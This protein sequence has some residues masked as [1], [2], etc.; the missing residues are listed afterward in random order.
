VVVSLCLL[1]VP[2]FLHSLFLYW[3]EYK[4]TLADVMENL[5]L[6]AKGQKAILEER[7]TVQWQMLDADAAVSD[8]E[9]MKILEIF[10]MP[11]PSG[12][13][14]HFAVISLQK[15][16]LFSGK[17][18]SV[19]GAI[20]VSTPIDHVFD[21]LTDFEKAAYPLS[22]AFVDKDGKAIVGAKQ[23]S[24][25][26][27]Q[28]PIEGSNFFLYLSIPTGAVERLHREWYVYHFLS[29][30]FFVGLVGGFLVWLITRR[31]SKPLQQLCIAMEK[32]GEGAVHV[33]YI[34]DKM[35]FEI[36][37]LGKQFNATL[38]ELLTANK[39]AEEQRVGRERL[40]EELKIGHDIQES[41]LP[42]HLP[43]MKGLDIAGGF[44]PS[45]EVGG[46]FY[47]I[48]PM[49]DGKLLIV[50]A[51][52]AGKGISACLFS[53]GLRSMF[54]ALAD[55]KMSLTQ[56]VLRANDLFWQDAMHSG[57]FV[58]V[59]IGIYDPG[60]NILE[61]STQ[62]H[63]PAY[64]LREGELEELWTPGIALGAQAL[65]MIS[66]KRERLQEGDLLFLYTDGVIESHSMKNQLFG[67]ERLQKFLLQTS[68]KSSEKMIEKLLS[69]IENFSL[70]QPQHD[71]I[72]LLAIQVLKKKFE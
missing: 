43:E 62:G 71:D 60:T 8:P 40:A 58:T 33:R 15:D 32:V 25:L 3:S 67:K 41:L 51:D 56:M 29:L 49:P 63:P 19:Q 69:E 10:E 22:L 1:V 12:L 72:T 24:S 61:Y 21:Q 35:G 13:P 55:G 34:P 66:T 45:R 64:L 5:E 18:I 36:N 54:R 23:E 4:D 57:M 70:G 31:I 26:S 37:E 44:L 11:M 53:L 46:D 20:A 39:E 6:T 42:S 16:A 68:S 14:N 17:R 47:D 27:V 2:L 50:I 28:L 9:L 52:T 30:L 38:E 59:W 48:F 7:I 65:D